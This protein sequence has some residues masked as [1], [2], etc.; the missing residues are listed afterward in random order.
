MRMESEEA[1]F[2]INSTTMC[3]EPL[4]KKGKGNK[5]NKKFKNTK[6]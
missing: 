4:K 3:Y 1:K 2:A 5:Y 6:E